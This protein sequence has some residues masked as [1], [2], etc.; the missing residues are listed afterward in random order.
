MKVQPIL[1]YSFF[2]ALKVRLASIFSRLDKIASIS[3]LSL[4]EA[5]AGDIDCTKSMKYRREKNWQRIQVSKGNV[6]LG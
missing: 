4:V 5:V 1:T 6:R 3:E 2:Q